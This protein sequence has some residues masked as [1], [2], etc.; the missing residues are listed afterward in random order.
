MQA[1]NQKFVISVTWLAGAVALLIALVIPLGYFNMAFN[2]LSAETLITAVTKSEHVEQVI[3]NEPEMWKY[4]V[5][6]LDDALAQHS[7][8]PVQEHIVIVDLANN[9]VAQLGQPPLW[10]VLSRSVELFDSGIVIGRLEVSRSLRGVLLQSGAAALLGLVLAAL[11]FLVLRILPLRLLSR[12]FNALRQEKERTQ[13]TLRSIGDGVITTDPATLIISMNQVAEQLTGWRAEEAKGRP[14]SVVFRIVDE[15]TER[16]VESP[17]KRALAEKSIMPLTEHM[18]LVRRDGQLIA[19]ENSAAPIIL[20]SGDVAGGVLIFRNVAAQRGLSQKLSWQASHDELTGLLNRQEFERHLDVALESCRA[21]GGQHAMCYLDLDQFK[22]INDTC[23]HAAGD[24]LLRQV[25]ETLQQQVRESDLLARLGGDEFGVLL[26]GCTLERAQGIAEELLAAVRAFRFTWGD[27]VFDI[28]VSIGV[29]ALTAETLNREQVMSAADAACYAAKDAGRNRVVVYQPEDS[30][31]RHRLEEMN[32][33]P[34]IIQALDEHRLALYYQEYLP[35]T[36]RASPGRHIE[37]LLRMTDEAGNVIVPGAFIPAAE[38]YNLM[39]RIDQWVIAKVFSEYANLTRSFGSDF[40]CSI[41]LSGTSL[42]QDQLH[43]FI[44]EQAAVHHVRPGA[45]CFEITE[46]AAINQLR[47]ASRFI[48]DMKADGFHFA[49]DDFG[50]GMSSFAYLR[51]LAV[52]FLKIDGSF[53]MGMAS[54]PINR[55]MVSAINE[56]GHVMGLQTIA[57]H[58]DSEAALMQLRLIGVDFA[59][60]FLVGK[61]VPLPLNGIPQPIPGLS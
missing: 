4:Q 12:A 60:G 18:V 43:K 52:D 10:P 9:V 16:A 24:E 30:D 42:N 38:R 57:E 48:I 53:V 11:V 20:P 21:I 41:N 58:V 27:R 32:W 2:T 47:K 5:V 49:L 45:I 19:I 26:L 46:T 34:R 29:V 28:G 37:V 15:L 56:I 40:S 7:L 17:L 31:M 23:G 13:V 22:I 14:L 25:A 36:S 6:R 50:I 54:D 59:Q 39:P 61:P 33:T 3:N 55:A 1:P 8:D 35:L 44:R 51:N